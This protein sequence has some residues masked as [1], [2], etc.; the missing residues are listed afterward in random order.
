MHKIE[1]QRHGI[2]SVLK[3]LQT[4]LTICIVLAM[5]VGWKGRIPFGFIVALFVVVFL[6]IQIPSV[7]GEGFVSPRFQGDNRQNIINN[8]TSQNGSDS[9]A[10]PWNSLDDRSRKLIRE[11]MDGKTFLRQMP[12][13][14]GHCDLEM[15]DFMI[16]HPDVV[17][18]LWELLGVTQISLTEIGTNKYLLKEGTAT[19][20][21]VEVLYKSKNLCIVYATGEYEAP[22]LRR[23]I[24]GDVVLVLKSR[25]GRDKAY[26]PVVQS[27]LDVYVRIHNPGAEMLAKMLLPVVGKIADSN[28][29]QTVGFVM[30]VSEA[31]QE[32]FEPLLVLA[33]R[34]ESVRPEVAEEFAFVAEMVFDREIDRYVAQA[35]GTQKTIAELAH[36]PTGRS[37]TTVAPVPK[38]VMQANPTVK[39]QVQKL[40]SDDL[41]LV[42]P[43]MTLEDLDVRL[44]PMLTSEIRQGT[45]KDHDAGELT[46]MAG[47]VT[48][49]PPR[50]LSIINDGRNINRE[51]VNTNDSQNRN[52][53]RN[54]TARISVSIPS[55][56]EPS[57]E[58]TPLA[59]ETD[60]RDAMIRNGR[61]QIP[62]QPTDYGR[63]KIG[64]ITPLPSQIVSRYASQTPAGPAVQAPSVITTVPATPQPA[65]SM[66]VIPQQSGTPS[67]QTPARLPLPVYLP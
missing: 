52:S 2:I 10:I 34:M 29:E 13:Q 63:V 45:P 42:A 17:V 58:N 11:V 67:S 35:T 15:Y 31:A 6:L 49:M 66:L 57:R 32:D 24:K 20:S 22:V 16:S 41:R 33:K 23:K 47:N 40:P 64:T 27:D 62:Q 5:M 25:Y 12:Q 51:I 1:K 48:P 65:T 37:P 36:P 19:T 50:R 61:I 44:I 43:T 54:T 56:G 60:S 38:Y 7:Q 14:V 39:P 9:L 3:K 53:Q 28:F 46:E 4:V 21:Q 55:L 8:E 59:F 26:R 18:E 30:N